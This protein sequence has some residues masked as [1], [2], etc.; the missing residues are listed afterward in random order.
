MSSTYLCPV[1]LETLI[2][3]VT[4]GC[5][6]STCSA[7][8]E[9]LK[10][11]G[12]GAGVLNCPE[13]RTGISRECKINIV[14]DQ[15]FCT[16]IPDYERLKTKM[17]DEIQRATLFKRYKHSKRYNK[18]AGAIR[19]KMRREGYLTSTDIIQLDFSVSPIPIHDEIIYIIKNG[20]VPVIDIT[21][22]D[23]TYYVYSSDVYENHLTNFAEAHKADLTPEHLYRI[24]SAIDGEVEI[25][26]DKLNLLPHKELEWDNDILSAFLIN[27]D[28]TN[29]VT[30]AGKNKND[31]DDDS[32]GSGDDS[33]GSGSGTSSSTSTSSSLESIDD[34]N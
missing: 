18:I 12:S 8:Y 27:V 30:E 15:V 25:F 17:T 21:L 19:Q 13:C 14:L 11:A 20:G 29:I 28:F 3:P 23:V 22:K 33:S 6:H 2:A 10:N 9:S 5:G 31:D 4:F 24:A 16:I 7:C 26:F 1:C 32:S 34:E